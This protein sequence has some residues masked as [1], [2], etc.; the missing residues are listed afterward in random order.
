MVD[1]ISHM[2][3][4]NKNKMVY[5]VPHMHGPNKNKM[6][7]NISHVKGMNTNKMVD[8]ASHKHGPNK[9]KMAA[10][11]GTLA[12]EQFGGGWRRGRRARRLSTPTRRGGGAGT[13]PST[14]STR[15]G[16]K[17][18]SGRTTATFIEC[19]HSRHTYGTQCTFWSIQIGFIAHDLAD[20]NVICTY[21]KGI[22]LIFF[23]LPLKSQSIVFMVTK[24]PGQYWAF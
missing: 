11:C 17:T 20:L 2:Q 8:N 9:N 7:E 19:R 15:T 14:T 24:M 21:V 3:G 10:K 18:R 13:R 23:L 4:P 12:G 1:N 6:V 5:N 16:R 22:F